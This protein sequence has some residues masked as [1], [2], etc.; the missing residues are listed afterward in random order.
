LA[1]KT[2]L[3]ANSGSSNPQTEA[4]YSP[5]PTVAVNVGTATA[6][7]SPYTGL[8]SL[9][10]YVAGSGVFRYH[11]GG[12]KLYVTGL[13][14]TRR[15]PTSYSAPSSGNVLNNEGANLWRVSLPPIT[16]QSV[17]FRIDGGD[18]TI[19]TKWRLIVDGKYV[20]VAEPTLPGAGRRWLIVDFGSVATRNIVFEGQ[21]DSFFWGFAV[22]PADTVGARPDQSPFRAI[23]F[24][25]SFTD[26]V[27]SSYNGNALARVA[28]D[29]LVTPDFWASGEG[30]TGYLATSSGTRPR[31]FDRLDEDL[32]RWTA[33]GSADLVLVAMGLGDLS[34][35][36]V[37]A[38]ANACFNYIRANAPRAIVMVLGPWD[39]NAPSPVA[40]GYASRKGEIS[41]AIA[42]RGGFYFIDMEGVSFTKSDG[43]HPNAAGH[44]ALGQ[45]ISTRVRA[46]IA[47][48]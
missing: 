21:K 18:A 47:A 24:G 23:M 19:F 28:G 9:Y 31:L 14:S 29:Y 17:A 48:A 4:A 2:Y 36:D 35:G 33:L 44:L 45:E 11:G 38:Q 20:S 40:A 5:S 25:D 41:A 16:G 37:S 15:F 43:T 8:T 34:L 30:G 22:A 32:L 3:A 26:G 46:S 10:S 39:V 7:G 27:G 6:P 12:D 13:L 42:S 1:L